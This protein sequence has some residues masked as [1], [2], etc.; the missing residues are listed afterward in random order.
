MT[1]ATHAGTQ[2]HWHEQGDGEPLV[3]IMGLGGSGQAWW[4]LLRNLPPS[5]RAITLDNRG[6]GDSD[7]IRGRFSM[8]EL[9][10][11]VLCVLDA[12]GVER[13]HLMGVSM[14]GMVAQRLALDHPDRVASL[15]LGST[16]A[17][18][19]RGA[20]PWRLLGAGALRPLVG[21]E[22]TWELLAP[23][24]YAARTLRDHPELVAE[25]LRT[26]GDELQDPRTVA[27]QLL[28]VAGHNAL[29]RLAELAGLGVTILHGA[30]DAVVP[31][32]R[33]RELAAAIP[34]ARLV[35]IEE[36]GHMMTTDAEVAS[37]TAVLEH[38][39]RHAAARSSRAA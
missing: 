24:L 7:P 6:T 21:P 11:D 25:D 18:G 26:R 10:G 33:A 5:V 13:A 9:V 20:P 3:L 36:C 19:L 17:V 1:V 12:A 29:G 15:V 30:Q 31:A 35:I 23:A 14:G 28:A 2:I 8:E 34:G 38:L 32:A 22:R 27:A 39:D 37:A 4:R 16:T